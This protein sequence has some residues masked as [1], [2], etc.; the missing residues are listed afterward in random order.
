MDWSVYD[1]ADKFTLHDAG[2]LLC[3]LDPLPRI[4]KQ[5]NP[6]PFLQDSQ[7]AKILTDALIDDAKQ[8]R[9][10][11]QNSEGGD[12]IKDWKMSVESSR[13]GR[14]GSLYDCS[15]WR[16]HRDDLKAWA[17]SKGKKP[18]FLFPD[19]HKPRE[20]SPIQTANLKKA[21]VCM[22][23]D[24]YGYKPEDQRSSIPGELSK[25]FLEKF[26]FEISERTIRDWLKEGRSLL[27]LTNT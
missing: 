1:L 24:G 13:E 25:I 27:N 9:L 8:G 21:L 17:V 5:Q 19:D 3:G 10:K 22:A 26:G 12:G 20:D 15:S 16:V 2:F 7:K 23:I 18:A 14:F 4:Y 6:D 11:V